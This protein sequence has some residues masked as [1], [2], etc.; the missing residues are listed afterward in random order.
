MYRVPRLYRALY[1]VLNLV[2]YV[3]SACTPYISHIYARETIAHQC[4]RAQERSHHRSLGK[5]E[6]VAVHAV[7]R[8]RDAPM[9]N[10]TPRE[11]LSYFRNFLLPLT[12]GSVDDREEIFNALVVRRGERCMKDT[13]HHF[14]IF[15]FTLSLEQVKEKKGYAREMPQCLVTDRKTGGLERPH[16]LCTQRAQQLRGV[17]PAHTFASRARFWNQT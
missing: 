11:I 13:V 2:R 14:G 8:K 4:R 6:E 12:D 16:L 9:R 10:S 3:C 15:P 1:R 7:H 5:R 17:A